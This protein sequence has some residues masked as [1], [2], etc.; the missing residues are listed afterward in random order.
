V[1][2]DSSA[3]WLSRRRH[4]GD[5]GDLA[6]RAVSRSR[7]SMA[8]PI[9]AV[10]LKARLGSPVFVERGFLGYYFANDADTALR[11]HASIAVCALDRTPTPT[12]R[13]SFSTPAR[14]TGSDG[15]AVC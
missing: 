7:W 12:C 13:C 6:P 2:G 10:A 5:C 1:A 14:R 4:C 3:A 15:R 11:R 8:L 9:A